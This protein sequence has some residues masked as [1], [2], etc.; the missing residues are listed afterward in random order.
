LLKRPAS[1]FITIKNFYT[2]GY[3]SREFEFADTK[4][5]MLGVELSGLRGNTYKRSQ[6]KELVYGA[7]TLSS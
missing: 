4:V 3:D 5:S 2:M 1:A 6:E 7:G